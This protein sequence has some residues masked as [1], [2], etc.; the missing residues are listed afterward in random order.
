MRKIVIGIDEVGRGSWAGPLFFA[1]VCFTRSPELP[2]GVFI[3]DSK[4]L[5]RAQRARSSCFLRKNT[6]YVITRV[7]RGTIDT[8]G[9]QRAT[10]LG[11]ISTV[12][13]IKRKIYKSL[14]SA[15]KENTKIHYMI[16][17]RKICDIKE[18]HEYVIKGD[19]KIKEISAASIIAKVSRDRH[20]TRLGKVYPEYGFQNHMG[21]GTKEHQR[22]LE[23]Y[24]VCEIHRRSYA[25]IKM[26]LEK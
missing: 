4:A 16:D 17:G 8:I 2:P 23:R 26:L 9:L 10:I 5:N 13:R 12:Q 3:R 18:S 1:A 25:P 7:P 20:I 24:G 21:Y 15:Q 19:D 22:A 11:L 14:N 6:I